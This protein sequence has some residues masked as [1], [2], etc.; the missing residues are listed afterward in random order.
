MS[1]KATNLLASPNIHVSVQHILKT[2]YKKVSEV[3]IENPNQEAID[4]QRPCVMHYTID[5]LK[6]IN[7]LI[8]Q[9]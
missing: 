4:S 8:F 2:I 1:I 3:P 5:I 9:I 7:K 6:F